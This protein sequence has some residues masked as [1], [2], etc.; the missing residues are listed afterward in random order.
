MGPK[1]AIAVSL[2]IKSN[3]WIV[4]LTDWWTISLF[5]EMKREQNKVEAHERQASAANYQEH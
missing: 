1:P 2:I 4:A 5:S 3:S